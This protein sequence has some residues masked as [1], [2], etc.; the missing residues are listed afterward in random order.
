MNNL[1]TLL[2]YFSPEF[3]RKRVLNEL[4]QITAR[5]F[6]CNVPPI[7]GLPYPELLKHYALFTRAEAEKVLQRHGQDLREIRNRLFGQAE[8]LGHELRQKVNI[9]TD[10]EVMEL[11]QKL[12]DMLGINFQGDRQGMVTISKCFFSEYYSSQVCQLISALD[13]G[14]LTGLS[15]GGQLTFSQRIT[16]GNNCCQAQFISGE[17]GS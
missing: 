16:D 5:A 3:I 14:I 8:Q 2:K 1:I 11:G 17:Y 12:Y 7:K 6:D 9:S 15:G 10:A 4:F 13:E